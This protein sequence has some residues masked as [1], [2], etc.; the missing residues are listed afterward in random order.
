[1]VKSQTVRSIDKLGAS[2]SSLMQC[3]AAIAGSIRE[4]TKM[5]IT[6]PPPPLTDILEKYVFEFRRTSPNYWWKK[7]LPAYCHFNKPITDCF[8]KPCKKK[9]CLIKQH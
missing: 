1:M 6:R 2:I 4:K 8:L 3:F 7:V 9:L 5:D